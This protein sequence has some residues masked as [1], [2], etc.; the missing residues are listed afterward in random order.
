[1]IQYQHFQLKSYQDF[2]R[3]RSEHKFN[4]LKFSKA[5]LR[6]KENIYKSGDLSKM[7]IPQSKINEIGR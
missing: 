3:T 7:N 1:M 5:L 6:K 4:W 2:L